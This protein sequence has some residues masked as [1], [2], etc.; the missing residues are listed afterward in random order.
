MRRAYGGD[1]VGYPQPSN[2]REPLDR[3]TETQLSP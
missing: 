2:A 3:L 1:L